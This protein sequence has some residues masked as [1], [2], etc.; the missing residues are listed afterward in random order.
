MTKILPHQQK[1]VILDFLS[2]NETRMRKVIIPVFALCMCL[3]SCQKVLYT[4]YN[5]DEVVYSFAKSNKTF[6]AKDLKKMIKSYERIVEEGRRAR[7]HCRLPEL[8]PI[9]LICSICKGTRTRQSSISRKN[10][11]LIPKAKPI[12]KN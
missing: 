3:C 8:V 9:I 2:K 6:E 12:L 5:Y 10:I 11:L 7:T 4:H 1:N